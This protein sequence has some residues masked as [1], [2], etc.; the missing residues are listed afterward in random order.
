MQS[1]LSMGLLAACHDQ[2]ASFYECL[3]GQPVKNWDCG[4]DG[5][6]AIRERFCDSQQERIVT[7]MEANA[8]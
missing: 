6:A 7:C 4:P 1:C 3:L 5:I 8:P 2:V